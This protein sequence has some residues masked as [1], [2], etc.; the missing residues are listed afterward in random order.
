VDF[1]FLMRVIKKKGVGGQLVDSGI[2]H[3]NTHTAIQPTEHKGAKE[4]R[5]KFNLHQWSE[6]KF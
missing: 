5:L 2:V 4:L 1:G 6:N 3:S